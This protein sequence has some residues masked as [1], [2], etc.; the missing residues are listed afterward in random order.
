MKYE[1]G[2]VDDHQLFTKSLEKLVNDLPDFKVSLVA[3]SDKELQQ[4]MKQLSRSPD[5]M[6]LDVSLP[7]S[8]GAD[9]AAWLTSYYPEVKLAALT[10]NDQD[11]V[12]LSMLKA[13]CCSYMLKNIHP[14]EL[15]KAM[16][17]IADK[18]YYNADVTN[19]NFRRLLKVDN[20]EIFLTERELEFL[21]LAGSDDTYK[22]IALKM[23]VAISTVD[24]YRNNLFKK[25]NVESR[26]GMVLEAVR[27][28]FIRME[29]L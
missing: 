9:I 6:L 18:G 14:T 8:G 15:E 7:E 16:L 20:P 17:E 25:F 12:I 26:T 24:G 5:I 29:D 3:Y 1:I 28:G 4:K 27:K 21:K 2:L 10:M 23:K 19:I 13:G 11:K 22:Q